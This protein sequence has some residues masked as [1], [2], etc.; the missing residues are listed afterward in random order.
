MGKCNCKISENNKD[1]QKIESKSII[2]NILKYFAKILGFLIG[3]ILLPLMVI[4]IIWFMFDIMV[5]NKNVDLTIFFKK[6]V[7]I[8]K[9]IFEDED[10]NDDDD[11]DNDDEE[12]E[13]YG[14]NVYITENVEEIK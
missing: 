4:G 5:L 14:D 7:K 12:E 10:D 3:M 13:E 9:V 1:I 11:D 2:Q 8:N 6:I